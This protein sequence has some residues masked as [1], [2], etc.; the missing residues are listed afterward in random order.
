MPVIKGGFNSRSPAD[1]QKI[2]AVPADVAAAPVPEETVAPAPES[3]V[4]DFKPSVVEKIF[5]KRK[6]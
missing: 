4:P 5:G 6:R 1:V 3:G 2:M